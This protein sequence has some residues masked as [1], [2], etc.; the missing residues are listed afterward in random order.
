LATGEE[1]TLELELRHRGES[2]VEIEVEPLEGELTQAN[3][4]VVLP[5]NGIRD[6]LRV[7]LVSGEPHAGERTWRDLLKAD[8]SVDLVHFT[9]LRPPE[10]QDGTPA[11][12]LALIAF[13]TRQLFAEKLDEFDLIIFDRYRRR[14]VLPIIYLANVARYVEDGGALLAAAGP[15]FASPF[16]LFRTPLAEVLPARPSG[17]I[18][19]TGF[20]P[21]V[22]EAGARHPVT[23]E[24]PGANTTDS[25]AEWGRWFRLIGSNQLSG[26]TLML[27]PQNQPLLILDKFGDG[28]IAQLMSDQAWLWTRG[29]EGGGPQAEMLRRLAHWLMKEPELEE[30]DLNVVMRGNEMIIE[31]QTMQPSLAP[32]TVVAPSGETSSVELTQVQPG[33]WT[34]EYEPQENGLFHLSDGTLNK[35]AAVGPVNTKEFTE[36]RGTDEHLKPLADITGG[37]VYWHNES[38]TPDIHAVRPGR[39]AKGQGWLGLHSNGNFVITG[40]TQTKFIHALWAM[41]LLL[42]SLIL[43]WRQEAN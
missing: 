39:R 21:K 17:K 23:S 28:R 32:I 25:E 22:S 2:I 29:F 37:G 31:R 38:G 14:G 40:I 18:Y 11:N 12:E 30:E 4:R 24:L 26:E 33:R 34:G 41:L 1:H 6:R 20:H 8:P 36:V 7:L 10:K 42:G 15:S 13:P 9:I 19:E 35:L 5:I 43:M 27:G 16:S 3:N